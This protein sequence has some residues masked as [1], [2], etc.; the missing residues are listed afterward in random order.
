M[1]YHPLISEEAM[2]E[3]YDAEITIKEDDGGVLRAYIENNT[4]YEK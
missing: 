3:W 4:E 2:T 1:D